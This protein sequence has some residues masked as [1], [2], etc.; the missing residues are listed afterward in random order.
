MKVVIIGTGNVANVLGQKIF[1][2]GNEIIQLVGRDQETAVT[3][4]NKLKSNFERNLLKI[5]TSADLYVIAISDNAIPAIAK[6]LKLKQKLVVH[7]A[8]SVSKDVL[9]D[10]SSNYGVLYPLQTLKAGLS[11]SPEIP[12]AVDANSP[13]NITALKEF[14]EQW[15]D[16]VIVA[17]DEERLKIH[18]AAVFASNFTNHLFALAEGYLKEE[19]LDFS[20]IQPLIKETIKRTKF[21]SPALLQTGPALRN[22]VDTIEKHKVLL[23]KNPPLLRVYSELTDSII[24]FY[25]NRKS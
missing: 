22:D 5:N 3:L 6:K 4:A 15:A 10:T 1:E 9:A 16:N 23:S 13:K 18:I 7:T 12:V 8:A 17:A 2:A 24:S 19:G 14:A 20:I 21:S 25:D 11:Y